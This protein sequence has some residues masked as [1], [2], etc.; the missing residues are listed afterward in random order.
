MNEDF[1]PNFIPLKQASEI[2]G[3]HQDYL[4]Q[5]IRQKKIKGTKI[6]R[7][8]FVKEEEIKTLSTFNAST[9]LNTDKFRINR[10]LILIILILIILSSFIFVFQK[11]I[12]PK[13][14]GNLPN[15]P[16]PI[17]NEQPLF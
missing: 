7:N 14:G 2:S 16:K 3:Y 10:K 1:S 17:E 9:K 12:R 5:L 15:I 11:I 4:S 13:Q 6:G 8:W